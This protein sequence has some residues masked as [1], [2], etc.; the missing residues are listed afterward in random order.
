MR[1]AA[2]KTATTQRAVTDSSFRT[3]PATRIRASG[4]NFTPLARWG[5]TTTLGTED[6]T[7]HRPGADWAHKLTLVRTEALS[8]SG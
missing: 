6:S 3:Y 4:F 8:G 1:T 2:V 7:P 5:I